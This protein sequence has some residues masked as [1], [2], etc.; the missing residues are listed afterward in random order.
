MR[1]L[2]QA[3]AYTTIFG[4]ES[5][6]LLLLAAIL[7]QCLGESCFFTSTRFTLFLY[8]PRRAAGICTGSGPACMLDAT[9]RVYPCMRDLMLGNV[10]IDTTI[11]FTPTNV[12]SI[13][14]TLYPLLEI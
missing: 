2:H 1:H 13:Y 3:T 10:V 8:D 5:S 7:S 4:T 12:V 9:Q 11:V 14:Q 6:W